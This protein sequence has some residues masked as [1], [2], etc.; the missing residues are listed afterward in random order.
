MLEFTL[1]DFHS[2]V[3]EFER[4]KQIREKLNFDLNDCLTDSY[5]AIALHSNTMI[6]ELNQ[7]AADMFGYSR[8]ELIGYNAWMLFTSSSADAIMQH[9]ATQSERAYQ[10]V[11]KRKDNTTFKVELKGIDFKLDGEPLRMVMLKEII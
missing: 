9:V 4:V 11:G 5:D 7:A 6:V 10:I 8:E 3:S 2:Q 1:T